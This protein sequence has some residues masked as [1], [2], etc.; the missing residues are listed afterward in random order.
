MSEWEVFQR[1]V[2]D[3]LR[4]Y[5]GYFD[6]FERVGSLSDDSRPDCFGRIS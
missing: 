3:V 6:Y 4:Q 2:L 5:E 1:D